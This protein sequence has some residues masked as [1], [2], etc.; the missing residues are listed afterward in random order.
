MIKKIMLAIYIMFFIVLCYFTGLSIRESN[1]I[2]Y[3]EEMVTGQVYETILE[4]IISK[5]CHPCKK[6]KY[7]ALDV[8]SLRYLDNAQIEYVFK[9]MNKESHLVWRESL[10]S[11]SNKGLGEEKSIFDGVFIRIEEV[12]LP[13]ENTLTIRS[14][15]YRT[16]TDYNDYQ[17]K[18]ILVNHEWVIDDCCVDDKSIVEMPNAES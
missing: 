13:N 9:A 10:E 18:L 15:V 14:K 1:K 17:Y 8:K 6:S 4:D 12:D 2:V 3:A 16:E 7:I 5:D 11:F